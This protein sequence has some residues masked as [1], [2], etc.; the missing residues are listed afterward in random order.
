[1]SRKYLL[2]TGIV[3]HLIADRKGV[4]ANARAA[5]RRG[6]V[7]GLCVTVLG[8]LYHGVENSSDPNG[9]HQKMHNGIRGLAVWPYSVAAAAEYGRLQTYLQRMGRPMQQNDVQI[10]AIVRTLGN[11]ILVSMDTDFAA[12]PGLRV[13]DWTL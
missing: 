1:M 9:N 8:E 10:A 7:I 3:G 13:E 4:R 6:C 5:R 12:I 2:D 11:C